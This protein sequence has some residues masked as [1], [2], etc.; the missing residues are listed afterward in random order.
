MKQGGKR[1]NAIS[2]Q[3]L[4]NYSYKLDF[5]FYFNK[6]KKNLEIFL[7]VIREYSGKYLEYE[8]LFFA[9]KMEMKL[10]TQVGQF[11]AMKLVSQ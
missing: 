1:A 11:T 5:F 10:N 3:K 2:P 8:I 7:R 9:I 6:K 4:H